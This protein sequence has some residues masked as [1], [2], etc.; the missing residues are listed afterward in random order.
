MCMGAS[1]YDALKLQVWCES[2]RCSPF[3]TL[4]CSDYHRTLLGS[5]D[6]HSCLQDDKLSCLHCYCPVLLA[7][8]QG[9]R[10]YPL[11]PTRSYK[12]DFLFLCSIHTPQV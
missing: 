10:Q 7:H 4:S 5:D 9:N 11:P 1:M 6:K 3:R 8:A 12:M 2:T